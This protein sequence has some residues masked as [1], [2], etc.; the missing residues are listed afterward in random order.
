MRTFIF[1]YNN[2]LYNDIYMARLIRMTL[3]IGQQAKEIMWSNQK[4][5]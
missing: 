2:L 4:Q 3:A 5:Q 1:M